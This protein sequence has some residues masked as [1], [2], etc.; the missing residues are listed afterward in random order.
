MLLKDECFRNA[1]AEQMNAIKQINFEKQKA[2][3]VIKLSP[4][5]GCMISRMHR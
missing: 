3:V 5:L 1:Y 4:V 2:L